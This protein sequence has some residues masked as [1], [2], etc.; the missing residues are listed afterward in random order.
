V[1]AVTKTAPTRSDS[2]YFLKLRAKSLRVEGLTPRSRVQPRSGG[3]WRPWR[4]VGAEIR[5][6]F[7][8]A[9]PLQDKIAGMNDAATEMKAGRCR[10]TR[11]KVWCIGGLSCLSE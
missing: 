7:A 9:K 11:A 4:P 8:I 2:L 1:A 5:E 10:L 6:K 3:V